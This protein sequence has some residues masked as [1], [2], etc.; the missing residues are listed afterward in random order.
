MLKRL[1]RLGVPFKTIIDGGANKGQFARAAA[2]NF[3]GAQ[4]ISFEPLPDVG[5]DLKKNLGDHPRFKLIKAALGSRNGKVKFH[6]NA[7]S[8][9]SSALPLHQ[10]HLLAFPDAQEAGELVVPLLTLDSAL[11]LEQLRG[12]SLLKLDLQG[13]ELEALKGAKKTLKKVNAVLLEAVFDP[14]YEG[15]AL[16]PEIERFLATQGFYFSR[17]LDFLKDPH[18]NIVQMDALFLKTER[19]KK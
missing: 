11:R 18:G 5:E 9:S 13:Y 17:A 10:N 1:K 15:E 7:H 12:P 16:F 6:R 8:H 3:P 19:K 2:E 14:L 4:I